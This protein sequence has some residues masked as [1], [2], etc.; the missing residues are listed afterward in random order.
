MAAL[1][2][3]LVINFF[4]S[5][6]AALLQFG[7]SVVL[8]RILSPSEIGVFSMTVVFV[9]IAHIFRDF[10][11]ATYIQREA[12]LTAEKIRSAI[13]VLFTTSWLI[14]L[15]LLVASSWLGAWFKEPAITPVM[16]VLALG[17]MITP[18]GSITHALLVRELAADK[19]AVVSAVSTI[20]YCVVCIG[21]ALLG[22]GTM[23]LAWANLANVCICA[24]AYIPFRP[25]GMPWLP[26]FRH[27]RGI[28]HFGLGTLLANCTA[29]I[30]NAIPDL[31]LGK[32]GNAHQVGLL[33]RA[34]STV[35]IFNYAAGS[36]VT[37][38][39]VSYLSQSHYRGET[40]VPV[41]TRATALLTGVGWPVFAFTALLGTDIV[42]TLYGVKWVACVPAILP[43]TIAAGLTMLFQY[44]PAALTAIGRPYLGAVPVTVT[45]LTRIA[46]GL[47]MYDGSLVTFA[48]AICLATVLTTPIM[49]LQQ[50]RYFDFG[51]RQFLRGITPS[52]LVTLICTAACELMLLILP[53][54]LTAPT[55]LAILA[56]PLTAV[57]YG[58][59]RLTRHELRDEV[60]HLVAGVKVRLARTA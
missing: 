45:L 26:S 50:R 37:Y 41:L 19:Q 34:N 4:V 11:V 21:L 40:L 46:F 12:E 54:S 28:T 56:L 29:A 44:T 24:V 10:G 52:V 30:N 14:A 32:L 53:V 33:S 47:L 31:L 8:A 49:L 60:H 58:A 15:L 22:C 13:G 25:A 51:I 38:G 43:L 9:N 5:S 42:V 6:G 55:R 39:A 36:T 23:S 1:R 7:V 35:S 59:L 48:W 17:F 20:G 18:F 27:W 16:R 57:W 3:S 2:R